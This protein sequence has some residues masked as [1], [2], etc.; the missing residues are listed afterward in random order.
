MEIHGVRRV[1]SVVVASSQARR[2]GSLRCPR[3]GGGGGGG[4][5]VVIGLGARVGSGSDRARFG[6]G[7]N[8]GGASSTITQEHD[9]NYGSVI[10][11]GGSG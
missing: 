3:V 2:R 6:A 9:P 8:I 5:C 10:W 7:P 1:V 4:T 11:L